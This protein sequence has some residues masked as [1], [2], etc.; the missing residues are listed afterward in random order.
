M[1]LK[2]R[3]KQNKR[4]DLKTNQFKRRR[5]D[6]KSFEFMHRKKHMH[7]RLTCIFIFKKRRRS[8]Y[9]TDHF[10]FHFGAST[11]LSLRKNAETRFEIL[12]RFKHFDYQYVIFDKRLEKAL[13]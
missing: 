5:E 1:K 4:H 11:E 6:R 13:E 3:R 9:K 10:I 12:L 7:Y 2:Y 8:D